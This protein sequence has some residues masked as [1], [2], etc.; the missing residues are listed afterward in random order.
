MIQRARSASRREFTISALGLAAAA[1]LG[2]HAS[3]AESLP[4]DSHTHTFVPGLPMAANARYRP[5]YDASYERLLTTADRNGIGRVVI[6][7]PSFLGQDNSYLFRALAAHPDRLR[8]V[9]WPEP[10][11]STAQW[12][13]MSRLGVVG[14]RFPIFGLQAP[15]WADYKEVFTEAKRRNWQLHLYVE[16]NRLAQMLPVLLETG[17]NV[18]IPHMGMFDPKVGPQNDTGFKVMIESAKTRRVYVMF[19]AS[20]R[21]SVEGARTA[22]PVLLDAFG[23]DHIIWGSD[24]PHTNT[25]L[26]RVA[27]YP[28]MLQALTEWVPDQA[29]RRK[30]LVDTPTKLFRFT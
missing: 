3:A 2:Q 15:N 19:T 25:D 17:A 29:T 10:R 13:E 20:Y 5:D 6:A 30:I 26:D 11:T 1:L 23:P 8:G 4:V 7:Q 22:V 24:W 9:P 14:L 12:D 21:T 28:R 27:T 18:V 16:S